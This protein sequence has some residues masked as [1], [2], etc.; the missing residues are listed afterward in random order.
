VVCPFR[1]ADDIQQS[2][3]GKKGAET[4][5]KK[6][7]DGIRAIVDNR[8]FRTLIIDTGTEA[9]ELCRLAAFGKLSQVMPHH[10][11]EVNAKFK[12]LVKYAYERTDLNVIWVHKVKK[13]YKTNREGKD[14]WTGRMERA[15]FGDMP[16]LVDCNIRHYFAHAP[17]GQT[18]QFGVEVLDSRMEMISVV[19]CRFEGPDCNFQTLAEA[20][21]PETYGEGL[22]G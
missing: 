8:K 22:W 13:E 2:G 19:G 18:G 12:A 14:T 6:M 15:G 5:W 16:Y 3:D 9:W 4:E 1:S 11:V 17:E 20:M 21:F 7:D 10:Y